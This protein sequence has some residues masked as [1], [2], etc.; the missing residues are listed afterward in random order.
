RLKEVKDYLGKCFSVKDLGE[1]AYI[2]RIKIYRDRS[3]RLIGHNQSAY[4]DKI[5]KKFNMQNSKK[6]YDGKKSAFA[7]GTLPF[8][9]KEFVIVVPE[10]DGRQ[11]EFKVAMKFVATKNIDH[12]RQSHG[13][14]LYI[15]VSDF[16][17]EYHGKS[18]TSFTD[19]N[20]TTI[21]IVRYYHETYDTTHR[22]SYLP[23]LI[24]GTD[25]KPVYLPMEVYPFY[26]LVY[27]S[28]SS[29]IQSSGYLKMSG[30]EDH[31]RQG[32][33]FTAEG[34]GH[35]RRDP[36][37]VEIERLRQRVRDLEI[38]HEI[39]QIRK[40]I[41]ELELQRELTK[42]TDSEP[43]IWDIGDEEEGYPFVNK[44]PSLQEHSMLVEEESCP[45]CDTDNEEE[46]QDSRSNH[47][48]EGK[49][50]VG[51][52]NVD[53]TSTRDKQQPT[54]IEARVL[55]PPSLKYH[56]S[57]PQSEVTPSVGAWNMKNLVFD[58]PLIQ[59]HH[60][61]SHN[62]EKA[63]VDVDLQFLTEL[64]QR[65]PGKSLWLLIVILP[66]TTGSYGLVKR[67]LVTDLGIVSQCCQPKHVMMANR[68]YLENLAMKINVKPHR[69]EIVEDL[70]SSYVDAKK[71]VVHS[72]MIRSIPIITELPTII[73]GAYVTHP[74]PGEYSSSS[75]AAVVASM[76]WPYTTKYQA[77][78][79]AQPHRKEIVEDLY[80]SY[81]DAKKRCCSFRHD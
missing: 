77:L 3:L 37:D 32:C 9:N 35:D 29:G 4:I 15:L 19:A 72:G 48:N 5:L 51:G 53:A 65:A 10:N 6:A 36:R 55:P 33:R 11:R 28:V 44:Y 57:G 2:M 45:V 18:V 23:A 64:A 76:D 63:L 14:L 7:A 30:N 25:A 39:R 67:V 47:Y 61:P 59:T 54:A 66:D 69:Q 20:G 8:E 41:R 68:Q 81:V 70:Y 27:E 34:N 40:R 13:F 79:S 42:E 50:D 60:A 16:V 46:N 74:Q 43:I 58:R 75:I 71:G 31:H 24:A 26:P 78:M 73:F 1:A 56:G 52:T 12:L 62:I 80:S 38:Q 21:S 22:L 49:I 17:S